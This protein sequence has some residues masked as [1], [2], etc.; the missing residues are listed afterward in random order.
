MNGPI[1]VVYTTIQVGPVCMCS[2]KHASYDTDQSFYKLSIQ[3][4]SGLTHHFFP[5]HFSCMDFKNI[6]V[7]GLYTLNQANLLQGESQHYKFFFF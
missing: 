4:I 1:N 6:F 2:P 3:Y 5:S 7:K